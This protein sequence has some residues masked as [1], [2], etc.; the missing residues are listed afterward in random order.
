[1]ARAALAVSVLVLV[2]SPSA[3]AARAAS[4]PPATPGL[5]SI[6]GYARTL[7]QLERGSLAGQGGTLVSSSQRIWVLPTRA[8]QRVLAGLLARG[9][10]QVVEPDL[11]IELTRATVDPLVQHE[12]WRPLVGAD[13]A[14]PP[15]PGKPVTVIDTGLDVTHEEA[16]DSPRPVETDRP[17]S[18]GCSRNTTTI[19]S[20]GSGRSTRRGVNRAG[21]S[22]CGGRRWQGR[23]SP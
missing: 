7:V 8:A 1:L 10:V 18:V 16:R 19:G 20:P 14:T 17:A 5:L 15:G 22:C 6:G 9:V 3:F 2:V 13:A 12:Y 21:C 11:P 23:A 4:A